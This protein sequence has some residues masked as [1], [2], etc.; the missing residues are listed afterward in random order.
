MGPEVQERAR[1]A[2][3]CTACRVTGTVVCLGLSAYLA[4]QAYA[5][6][7]VS[8]AHRAFT[9]AFAG[10]FAALGVARALA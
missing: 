1:A 3:D 6:P 8:P 2:T 4:A 5:R 9:L 10:G 7:P